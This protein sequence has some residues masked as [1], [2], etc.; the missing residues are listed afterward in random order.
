MN[1]T[2]PPTIQ[3]NHSRLWWVHFPTDAPPL[4]RSVWESLENGQPRLGYSELSTFDRA[5]KRRTGKTPREFC[6]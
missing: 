3:P 5:F 4:Y 1:E 6:G 2:G